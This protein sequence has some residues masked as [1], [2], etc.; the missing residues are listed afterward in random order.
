MIQ[1]RK[2]QLDVEI[3]KTRKEMGKV[4]AEVI[5]AKLKDL[6]T[7]KDEVRI[8]FAAAPSQDDMTENLVR[9]SGIDWNRVVAFHMDEYIS[10]PQDAEQRFGNY[11]KKRVFDLLPFKE[12]H[13]I[14]NGQDDPVS[15][16]DDY[17]KKLNEAPIDIICMGIG[18][19]G[20]I[21]FNDP[22]VADFDDPKLVKIVELDDV[23]RQQQVNDGCFNS[24]DEVPKQAITLTVPVF[25]GAANLFCVVPGVTKAE[26]IKRTLE[27]EIST[28]CPATI[29][30][31]HPSAKLYLDKDSA[32]LLKI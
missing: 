10:L 25:K 11:L 13:Y 32:S 2:D 15:I 26:A 12:V 20:H 7:K 23:C 18:E 24:I 28:E 19:N 4:A 21:A 1:F 3:Y 9:I 14:D 16:C 29:L 22:P 5:A 17:S 30:R 6:L 31:K 8:I 27:G